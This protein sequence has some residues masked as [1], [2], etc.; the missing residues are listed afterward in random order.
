MHDKRVRCLLLALLL[1]S[2]RDWFRDSRMPQWDEPLDRR[3]QLAVEELY[4]WQRAVSILGERYFQGVCALLPETEEQLGWIVAQGE[5]LV[6]L[7][8]DHLGFEVYVEKERGKKNKTPLPKPLDIAALKRSAE[9]GA[10]ALVAYQ[11]ALARAQ[12]CEMM[13]EQ[14]R[15]IAYIERQ[16]MKAV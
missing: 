15:G 9:P 3:L 6:E 2:V 11:L 10:K 14:K 8:N 13:G 1:H 16:L 5:R 7:F 12:A 4:G